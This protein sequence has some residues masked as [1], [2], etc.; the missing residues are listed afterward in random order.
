L[1]DVD[2]MPERNVLQLQSGAPFHGR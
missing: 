1:K 2:L